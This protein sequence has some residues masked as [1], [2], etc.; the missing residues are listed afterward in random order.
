MYRKVI[1]F[2]IFYLAFTLYFK[3]YLILLCPL[4][5]FPQPIFLRDM[6]TGAG[7]AQSGDSGGEIDSSTV[8][9]TIQDTKRK[10]LLTSTNGGERILWL[11]KL[12]EARKHCMQTER[13]VLQRQRSSEFLIMS[14]LTA[15]I[16]F[17]SKIQEED[18]FKFQTFFPYSFPIFWVFRV[19]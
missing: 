7:G 11:R 19:K 2:F 4:S 9:F 17:Y 12:E 1:L 14:L 13:V 5:F 6:L 18:L 16:I 8:R 15:K 3:H 10:Y